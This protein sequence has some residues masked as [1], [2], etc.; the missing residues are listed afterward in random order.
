MADAF[1]EWLMSEEEDKA[2]LIKDFARLRQ[3]G[4]SDATLAGCTTLLSLTPVNLAKQSGI[5]ASAAARTLLRTVA[6]RA[7]EKHERH[8]RAAAA[9]TGIK[10]PNTGRGVRGEPGPLS[11]DQK[12]GEEDGGIGPRAASNRRDVYYEAYAA[13]VLA[14][15]RAAKRDKE[16]MA[17]YLDR[18]DINDADIARLLAGEVPVL[19]SRALPMK[20]NGDA[21]KTDLDSASDLPRTTISESQAYLTHRRRTGAVL[22][23]GAGSV[24]GALAVQLARLGVSPIYLVDLDV[25]EVVDLVRHPLGAEGLGQPKAF[26]LADRIRRDFPLCHAQGIN[27]NFLDLPEKEQ[28]R[29]ARNADVVVASTDSVRCRRRINEVCLV[30]EVPAVYPGI[31]RDDDLRDAEVSEVLWVLPGRHTPCYWC[32]FGSRSQADAVEVERGAG[33][34]IQFLVLVTLWVIAG[35]LDPADARAAILDPEQTLIMVH[36]IMPPSR[37]I[38]ELFGQ[39]SIVHVGVSFPETRCPACGGERSPK[40]QD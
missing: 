26:A 33:A 38:K 27:M 9:M 7:T 10:P 23:I 30:A 28:L 35:L 36:G 40:R 24:G 34:D 32:A 31:W 18:C 5:L 25:L 3:N 1:E 11:R 8:V 29:L 21:V 17:D 4:S 6:E 15:V 13:A 16:I 12:A 39:T 14:L 22:V 19:T 37:K 20:L 2:G